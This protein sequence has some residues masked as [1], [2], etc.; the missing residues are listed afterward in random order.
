MDSSHFAPIKSEFLC[1][2]REKFSIIAA[3]CCKALTFN[4]IHVPLMNLF[5]HHRFWH[6]INYVR[7]HIFG[8]VCIPPL[9][10]VDLNLCTS[11]KKLNELFI[12]IISNTVIERKMNGGEIDEWKKKTEID[13]T[14]QSWIDIPFTSSSHSFAMSLKSSSTKNSF[15]SSFG[16]GKMCSLWGICD[17]NVIYIT[18]SSKLKR[19]KLL[20]LSTICGPSIK[21]RINGLMKCVIIC[22]IVINWNVFLPM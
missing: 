11:I 3:W 5:D 8:V 19:N 20:H 17:I 10:K 15:S 1:V 18:L 12:I 6:A 7:C 4:T 16:P 13:F 14:S 22:Y 2:F 9:I 21:Y